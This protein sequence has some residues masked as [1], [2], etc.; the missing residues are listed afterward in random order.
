MNY[1]LLRITLTCLAV[2]QPL[3]A[4]AEDTSFIPDPKPLENQAPKAKNKALPTPPIALTHETGL[5]L[6]LLLPEKVLPLSDELRTRAVEKEEIKSITRDKQ[7]IVL[8]NPLLG[9]SSTEMKC[10]AYTTDQE[11]VLEII[12]RWDNP[13]LISKSHTSTYHLTRKPNGWLLKL[14]K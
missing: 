5:A 8:W 14:V 4:E 13:G 11:P 7:T 10:I 12:Y 2:V 3:P 6:F 9:T 1:M